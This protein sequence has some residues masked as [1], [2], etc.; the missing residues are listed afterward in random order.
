MKK[1]AVKRTRKINKYVFTLKNINTEE[2]D[3]K[4]K[5]DVVSN[6]SSFSNQPTNTTK[7][8]DLERDKSLDIISFLD[9]TK[10]NYQCHVSMIDFRTKENIESKKYNCFWC[11][12]PFSTVPIGCP[13]QYVSSNACKN[14]FSEISRDTYIIKEKITEYRY[15]KIDAK[16]T[17]DQLLSIHKNGYYIT[18]SVFCSFNCTK[19]FIKKNKH[20][21][22]YNMSENLLVKMY[23]DMYVKTLD[24]EDAKFNAKNLIFIEAAP[25]WRLLREYGGHLT[26]EEFRE[27]FNKILYEFH[28]VINP[29]TF[30]KPVGFIFEEKIKF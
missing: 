3:K 25:H 9:E 30:F 11:R 2:V 28:G 18:D 1:T 16:S 23:Y 4:Y 15:D 12:N 20:D 26:I 10:R 5:I 19:A 13:L 24:T 29:E 8:S 6:L 17:E 22:L 27:N 14:Y 21:S 7:L